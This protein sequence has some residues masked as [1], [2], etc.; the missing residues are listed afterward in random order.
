[1]PPAPT[2]EQVYKIIKVDKRND[3]G[4]RKSLIQEKNENAELEAKLAELGRVEEKAEL[5][6]SEE[7]QA[8]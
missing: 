8:A 3:K 5:E 2:T 4:V 1:M 6:C 7:D